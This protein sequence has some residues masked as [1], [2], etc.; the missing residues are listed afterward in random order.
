LL[1]GDSSGAAI[2][3]DAASGKELARFPGVRAQSS[4][5]YIIGRSVALSRDG[6]RALTISTKG[7]AQLWDVATKKLSAHFPLAVGG[8]TNVVFSP[9]GELVAITGYEGAVLYDVEQRAVR[10]TRST[11]S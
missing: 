4:H 7:E 1:I 5:D 11:S 8:V 10:W 3:I 9:R 6:S 2:A